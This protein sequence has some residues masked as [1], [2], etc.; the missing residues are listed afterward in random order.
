M[1]NKLLQAALIT[2]ILHVLVSISNAQTNAPT[3]SSE[4]LNTPT[5]FGSLSLPRVFNWPNL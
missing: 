2:L 3:L 4:A 5:I 1:K